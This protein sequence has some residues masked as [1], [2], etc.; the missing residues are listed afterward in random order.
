MSK[1]KNKRFARKQARAALKSS[2]LAT[3]KG[4][5]GKLARVGYGGGISKGDINDSRTDRNDQED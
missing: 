4:T 2:P 1:G 3:P 5:L